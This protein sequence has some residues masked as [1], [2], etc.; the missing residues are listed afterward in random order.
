M[1]FH[2]SILLVL[3]TDLKFSACNPIT[4]QTPCGQIKGTQN[5]SFTFRGIRYAEAPVHTKRWT[6]PVLISPKSNNCWSGVLNATVFGEN[7]VQRDVTDSSKVVGSEDCLFLNVWTPT[8]DPN[9]K[10]PV[11]VFIPGGSLQESGG[12]WPTYRPTEE[13][14]NSTQIVYVSMNYRLQAFGFMAL[15]LISVTS[16]QKTSGNYGFMDQIAVLNWVQEYITSFGGDPNQVT[17]FGQSSG[18]TSILAL[19]ASPLAKGLFHKAWMLSASPIMNKTYSDAA[20][21]NLIFLK[22]T[23]CTNI[24]CLYDMSAEDITKAV[25]WDI[26]P[27][28]AMSDQSDLP[29]LN[30][31]DGAIAIVDGY[32]LTDNPYKIFENGEG[33]DVPLMIGTTAQEVDFDP[34]P[35]NLKNWTWNNYRDHVTQKLG[36]FQGN[37]KDIVFQALQLYPINIE[38]PEFEFTSMV[39]DLRVTCPNEVMAKDIALFFTSDVYRY[40]VTSRPSQPIHTVGIPFPASYSMHMWDLFGFFGTIKDYFTP[41]QSDIMFQNNIQQEILAFVR[42]GKP[43][44]SAWSTVWDNVALLTNITEIADS[45]NSA[46]CHFWTITAKMLPYAWI[47]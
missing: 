39:S 29:V 36:T 20:N 10:L 13:L 3:F 28:W 9:A 18:G 7:C 25:P 40:V 6:E 26:Y 21:D 35:T 46:Q 1:I 16:I 32:V 34:S 24:T 30:H 43:Y 23:G 37:T 47:N 5:V 2:F 19:L 12:S 4:V 41:K 33:N 31:F 8:I 44:T 15:D 42:T 45:Y 38:T 17:I 22:R 27:Y 14:A 11:M